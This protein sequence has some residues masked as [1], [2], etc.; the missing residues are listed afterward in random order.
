[1][2]NIVTFE[3]AKRLKD[4][5]FP[6]PEP[7]TGQIWYGPKDKTAYLINE[8]SHKTIYFIALGDYGNEEILE[9]KHLYLFVFAPTATDILRELQYADLTFRS[10]K[11]RVTLEHIISSHDNPAE[12][13]AVAWLELYEKKF[14]E[15]KQEV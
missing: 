13:A 10:G 6:Q 7:A 11:F 15:K 8:V 4:A 12:A 1:M 5:G 14:A 2:E 3:T 9:A